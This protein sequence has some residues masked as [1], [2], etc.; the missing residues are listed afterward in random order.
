MKRI[1]Y[2]ISSMTGFGKGARQNELVAVEAELRSVNSRFLD[3]SFKL[4]REYAAYEA[5]L[6]RLVGEKIKRGRVDLYV[7]RRPAPGR[8]CRIEFNRPLFDAYLSLYRPLAEELG[9]FDAEAKRRFLG[10]ILCKREVAEYLEEGG[11][12]DAEKPC[13]FEA[14]G[15]ALREACR[16]R[17]N[18]G[19][20]LGEDIV[21]QF[22]QLAAL[23]EKIA[24]K[25]AAGPEELRGKLLE[26]LRKLAP[27]V[28]FDEARLL[29]E[30]AYL[31]DRIDVS[32][33][34]VRL[35]SHFS[36]FSAALA[37]SPNGRMLDFLVQECGR[38]LNTIASKAQQAE[39]QALVVQGKACLEKIKEQVQNVE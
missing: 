6:R 7:Q 27:E 35:E 37:A 26:R 2:A 9:C 32:E 39:V 4:P 22:T 20:K 19:L 34:L 5:D 13:L 38:E 18:E 28:A 14:V 1:N 23:R 21:A 30:T 12:M 33:E 25:A 10:D 16:V 11:S 15:E 36:Q 24:Q 17:E 29:T 3:F 31:S 8:L